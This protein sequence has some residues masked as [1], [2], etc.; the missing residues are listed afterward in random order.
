MRP[1]LTGAA[2]RRRCSRI[3]WA[4]RI[5]VDFRIPR[6]QR[7]GGAGLCVVLG[8]ERDGRLI[9]QRGVQALAVVDLVQLST[10]A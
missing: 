3:G 2:R 10:E 4:S 8:L 7:G 5:I 6:G 9:T 1:T